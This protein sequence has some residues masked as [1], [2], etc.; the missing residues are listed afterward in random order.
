[1]EAVANFIKVG[2]EGF[3]NLDRLSLLHKVA[4]GYSSVIFDMEPTIG[5]ADLCIKCNTLW[6]VLED[7]PEL[8][9]YLVMNMIVIN[10]SYLMLVAIIY[11]Y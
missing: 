7:T 2:G 4:T 11:V 10:I 5:F 3:D 1:M 8:P 9:K 6:K